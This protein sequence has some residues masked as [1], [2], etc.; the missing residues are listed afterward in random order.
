MNTMKWLVVAAL[1]VFWIVIGNIF[2]S[3]NVRY[4][5]RGLVVLILIAGLVIA[6]WD[7]V[8]VRVQSKPRFQRS[9]TD[10]PDL[11]TRGQKSVHHAIIARTSEGKMTDGYVIGFLRE[12]IKGY[13]PRPELGFFLDYA[14]AQA[15]AEELNLRD[16]FTKIQVNR[17]VNR[18]K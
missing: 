3:Q 5:L 17:I 6:I 1:V 15:Q 18:W 8:M 16:G 11:Q 2:G 10:K 4:A 13:T 14:S 12:G 9:A 7:R